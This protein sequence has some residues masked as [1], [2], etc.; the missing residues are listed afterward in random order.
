MDHEKQT[1]LNVQGMSCPSCVRHIREALGDVEGVTAVDVRLRDGMV[2]VRHEGERA[3]A[4]ALVGA[5]AEA[6]YEAEPVAA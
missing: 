4:A 6:G 1:T 2:V 5:L 3:S